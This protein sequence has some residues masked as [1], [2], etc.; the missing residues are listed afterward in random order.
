MFQSPDPENVPEPVNASTL[1]T[2]PLT[3][4]ALVALASVNPV[5]ASPVPAP[6]STL[7]PTVLPARLNVSLPSPPLRLPVT[8]APRLK[9]SLP[10]P[11]VRFAKF[12]NPMP[13]TVPS[14]WVATANVAPPLGAARMSPTSSP[15]NASIPVNVPTTPAIVVLCRLTVCA[16]ATEEMS[17]RSAL[18]WVPP[19]M[20]PL[21]RAPF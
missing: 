8:P 15:V 11:P 13:P 5:K 9:L 10:V 2:L 21:I 16:P 17:I 4:A 6:P 3:S 12:E 14:F 7:P 20:S 18:A 19:L 1:L